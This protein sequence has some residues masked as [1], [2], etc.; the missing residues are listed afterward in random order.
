MLATTEKN[1]KKVYSFRL[2]P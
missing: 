1:A 2:L